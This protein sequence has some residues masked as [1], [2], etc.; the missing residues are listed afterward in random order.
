MPIGGR[1]S[2]GEGKKT[3]RITKTWFAENTAQGI[4]NFNRVCEIW[5]FRVILVFTEK[6]G[7]MGDE[8]PREKK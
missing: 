8:V 7:V 3:K 5:I 2:E 4:M 1:S 6:Q